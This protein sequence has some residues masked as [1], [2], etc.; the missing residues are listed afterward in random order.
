LPKAP[1]QPNLAP[2]ATHEAS[3]PDSASVVP[4]IR[5]RVEKKDEPRVAATLTPRP[6]IPTAPPP[7]DDD[8]I[9]SNINKVKAEPSARQTRSLQVAT[10]VDLG[11]ISSLS[12][13]GPPREY[14]RERFFSVAVK[15]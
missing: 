15:K 11:L 10:V 2:A 8:S 14:A 1:Q 9:S 6:V 12:P 3:H 4:I 13:R 7:I 5:V